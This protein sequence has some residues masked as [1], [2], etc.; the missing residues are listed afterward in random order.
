[1]DI[2]L[3]KTFYMCLIK[4]INNNIKLEDI[5]IIDIFKMLQYENESLDNIQIEKLS[6]IFDK[7]LNREYDI[8]KILEKRPSLKENLCIYNNIKNF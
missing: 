5:N 8:E 7:C 1:M 4:N 3:T 2:Y 6:N